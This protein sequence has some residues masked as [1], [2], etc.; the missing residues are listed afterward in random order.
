[1]NV[2]PPDP[3]QPARFLVTLPSG[4]AMAH[5]KPQSKSVDLKPLFGSLRIDRIVINEIA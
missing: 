4:C 1:L 2:T 5:Y 3:S